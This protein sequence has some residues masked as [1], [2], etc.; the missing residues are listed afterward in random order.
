MAEVR[1]R[2]LEREEHAADRGAKGGS[3]A[4]GG[5]L[6]NEVPAVRVVREEANVPPHRVES[7]ARPARLIQY[8]DSCPCSQPQAPV[9]LC[10]EGH[11]YSGEMQY[12]ASG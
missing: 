5:T 2:L 4:G 6:A 12:R 3:E 11:N 1:R 8:S 10:L 9:Q 7:F